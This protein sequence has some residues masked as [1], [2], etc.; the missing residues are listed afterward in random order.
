MHAC[1]RYGARAGAVLR[2]QGSI[3]LGMPSP[4]PGSLC[5]R[6]GHAGPR[7][8]EVLGFAIHSGGLECGAGVALELAC[9]PEEAGASSGRGLA[10]YPGGAEA[11]VASA[12]APSRWAIRW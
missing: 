6:L 9:G 10:A 2:Y 3:G 8:R 12:G 11:D 1:P 5:R 7:G 4:L